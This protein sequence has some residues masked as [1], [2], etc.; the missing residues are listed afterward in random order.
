MIPAILLHLSSM[1]NSIKKRTGNMYLLAA[2]TMIP[3]LL[4]TGLV[5]N[6]ELSSPSI[7]EKPAPERKVASLLGGGNFTNEA[8]HST[9]DLT[10][11]RKLNISWARLNL[12]PQYYYSK[13]SPKTDSIEKVISDM[14]SHKITPMIL[15]E[16]Y[17]SYEKK[18]IPIGDYSKWFSIG[19]AYAETY[20]PGGTWAAERGIKDW[21]VTVFS[22]FNE[23]DVER[24]IPYEKYYQALK[25]LADGVHSVDPD[26][27]VIPGGFSSQNAFSDWSLKGY[28][29]AIAELLNNG[30]LDGL[31][32]H[33]YYDDKYAPIL[34]TYKNS[35]QNNFDQ[36]KKRLG[37]TR[38][39]HFY[40][41]EFNVK[42]SKPPHSAQ[43]EEYLAKQF[44]TAIWDNLGVVKNDGHTPATQFAM[45]W[46][47]LQTGQEDKLYGMR[48]EHEE[49]ASQT[50]SRTKVL[51]LVTEVTADASFE[52]LD[53]K[54]KGEYVLTSP[55]KKI[56]VWQNVKG[57]SNRTGPTYQIDNI[58]SGA[59]EL[60][61]YRW[62]GLNEVIPLDDGKRTV[63]LNNLNQD[64][65]YMFVAR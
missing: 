48:T 32:L 40:S 39:I 17:G 49:S 44:L 33:T 47:L 25:G 65:T 20:R 43:T 11:M 8:A 59:K 51:Q 28:G 9:N 61:V 15:F 57:W 50:V 21:G 27:K 46:S 55:G 53:P 18:G 4:L 54:K 34:G 45:P 7:I 22:A 63:T 10:Y 42:Q 30:T 19:Q 41:T 37:L 6:S 5:T 35:A 12:Y 36:I 3:F 56:W 58:P 64:E 52:Y 29:P 23:P 1:S 31:D 38:D 13:Q 14:Y 2:K 62:N 24:T 26:L 60:A 16:Y